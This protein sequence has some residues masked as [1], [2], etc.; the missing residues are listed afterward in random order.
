MQLQRSVLPALDAQGVKLLVCGIGSVE[1]GRIFSEQTGFPVDS[2]FVDDS[3]RS[4]AYAAAGTRNTRRD[5]RG[6]AVFEGVGS[7]WSSATNDAIKAR[8]KGDLDAVVGNLFNPGPYKPL[9]PKA[10]TMQ[11]SM[12][13]TMVQGASFVFDG[14]N[15]LAEHLDESS[16][17]HASIESLL[18]AALK[19]E[20]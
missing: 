8:G 10:S 18:A 19:E 9:M 3:D 20:A 16:G 11:R 7:M 1:S 5:A 2:L 13:Q 17:A 15:A 12:E 4:E 14:Q 6:K